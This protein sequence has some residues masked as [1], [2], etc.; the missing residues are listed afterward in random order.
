MKA[1]ILFFD[2]KP[3]S[4]TPWTETLRIYDLRTNV[5]FTLKTNPL[6][7]EDLQDFINCYNVANKLERKETERFYSFPYE[8][9]MER[10]KVNLD[11]F[12]LRDESSVDS[13]NLPDPDVIAQEIAENLEDALALTLPYPKLGQ[14]KPILASV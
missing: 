5:H 3:A 14:N 11:I 4:K 7:Y 13:D 2:K 8:R 9:L 10:D 1:N 6:K 12:W